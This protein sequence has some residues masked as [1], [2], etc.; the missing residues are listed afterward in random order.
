MVIKIPKSKIE[1]IDIINIQ[2]GITA[3]QVYSKYKPDFLINLAL[4]DTATKQNITNLKDEGVASGYLFSDE[5]IGIKNGN[6][7]V[8]T[9]KKDDKVQDFVSGSPI[10]VKNS[11]KCIDWGNKY[12]EY[13]AGEHI[14]SAIGFNNSEVI[15]YSSE[16]K[17]ALNE[18][19]QALI[20]EKCQ[21]AI[22]LDGGGSCHLQKGTKV[23]QKSTRSNVSWLLVYMKEEIEMPK[24][25]LDYGHG[26]ETAGKRSPDGTLMEYEFNRDVGRRI[27]AILQRHNVE[28]IET[29]EDDTD[30]SL[31]SRCEIANFYECNYFVSIHANAYT[32]SQEDE[33]GTMHLTFNSANGWEIYVIA[34]GG[35]AEQLAN[36][37]HK[38]SQE[39]GL[40]DRGVKVDNFQV[41]RDTDMPAVLIEHGFYTNKEECEKLKSDSFRQKCAECD[42]KGILEQLGINY[43]TDINA[44]AKNEVTDTNVGELVLTIGKKTY[45][46]NGVNKE[47]EIAPRI[48]NGRT[49]VPI[50]V[51][52]DLGLEVEWNGENQTVTV[53][54]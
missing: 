14:R 45:T 7:I 6:E 31:L 46:V 9:T 41:L 20:S 10:L 36:K 44:A 23:Y 1:K 49:L 11:Q 2:G 3:S 53:R 29:V 15:L 51:I 34:K 4:Y 43:V 52:R 33:E 18:L 39:L 16:K 42:A 24:V 26:K 22:N 8:W 25:C 47:M 30:V 19:S 48:E 37:I 5:G 40:K 54:R 27:K 50:A 13:I 12:S 35:K 32:T 17:M 28:V 21:F 38:Y